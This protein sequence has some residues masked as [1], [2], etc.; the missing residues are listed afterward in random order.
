MKKN[1]SARNALEFPKGFLWGSAT[2]SYQVEGGIENVDWAEAGRK[3]KVPITG[4]ACDH[5]N[6]YEKDFDI[7]KSLSQNTHRFS[8]EWARIEPEEGKFDDRE[9]EH[10]RKVLHVLKARGLEPF[11]TLWHFTLPIWFRDKGGFENKK[12]PE[13][14]GRYC[15]YVAE[16][17]G[18]EAK[19]WMTMNEPM[20]WL[21]NGYLRGGWPPFKRDILKYWKALKIL[22][23]SHRFAYIEMK[24]KN[25][26]IQI[27]I[28]K[29]NMDFGSGGG[30]WNDVRANFSRKFWNHKFLKGIR[31]CQDFIGVNYY[32]HI[33]FGK[34]ENLPRTDMGWTIYPDGLRNVLLELKEYKKPLYIT[35]NGI[36]D[37]NDSQR[38]KFIKDHLVAVHQAIQ[39]GADVR[40]FFYWSLLDNYEWAEGFTK[41]FGLVKI[42]Y[43][44]MERTI[45][46][47]AL[48]YK[49]ICE[50]NSIS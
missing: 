14:F 34:L 17:L 23:K 20:V 12:A 24:K 3:K 25:P 48:L 30:W 31:E 43:D 47:S 26:S 37:A 15:A 46:P 13:I 40:G 5:Y 44:T 19:F 29:Q 41:R 28:A 50:M 49:K 36:A 2:A 18:S 32:R 45:R 21:G 6:L 16:K 8:I 7:A 35:E 38:G 27:G 10:Y 4:K 11:V 33:A 22:M 42:N 39:G 1:V 9:I